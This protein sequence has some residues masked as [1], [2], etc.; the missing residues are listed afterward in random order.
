MR[1]SC[2][3]AF[4]IALS[5]QVHPLISYLFVLNALEEGG[6]ILA[7]GFALWRSD[8]AFPKW[9]RRAERALFL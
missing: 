9:S 6:F 1:L 3:T 4:E 8:S 2:S 5:Q 7:S